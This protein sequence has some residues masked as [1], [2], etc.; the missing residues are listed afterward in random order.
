MEFF[1]NYIYPKRIWA[2]CIGAGKIFTNTP[3]QKFENLRQQVIINI[4][5]I[6]LHQKSFEIKRLIIIN[7]NGVKIE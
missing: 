5:S 4:R 6:Y 1:R 7:A 3:L 2:K